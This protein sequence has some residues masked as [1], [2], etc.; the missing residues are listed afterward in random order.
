MAKHIGSVGSAVEVYA[1]AWQA[2]CIVEVFSA[3]SIE[4]QIMW[5]LS[6]TVVLIHLEVI[7]ERCHAVLMLDKQHDNG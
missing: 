3:A 7:E 6:I 4:I 1:L 5:F 2:A